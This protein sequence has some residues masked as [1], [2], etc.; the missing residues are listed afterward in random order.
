[1]PSARLPVLGLLLGT[2]T[3]P[4]CDPAT[5]YSVTNPCSHEVRAHIIR[6]DE[7][8]PEGFDEGGFTRIPPGSTRRITVVFFEREVLT[9]GV[10]TEGESEETF[11]VRQTD[12]KTSIP[13][14]AC[15]D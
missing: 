4:A 15:E 1:M 12:R 9:L 5:T 10:K 3:M 11:T 6:G 13:Q 14:D 8:S 2:L 7:D